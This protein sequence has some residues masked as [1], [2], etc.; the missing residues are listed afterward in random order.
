MERACSPRAPWWSGSAAWEKPGCVASQVTTAPC[1]FQYFLPVLGSLLV[2]DRVSQE[3]LATSIPSLLCPPHGHLPATAQVPPVSGAPCEWAGSAHSCARTPAVPA[4]G[5]SLPTPQHLFRC[6]CSS[7][8]LA[9]PVHS[10]SHAFWGSPGQ[11]GQG[12][13][14]SFTHGASVKAPLKKDVRGPSDGTQ[15]PGSP[16][17]PHPLQLGLW[18]PLGGSW[19]EFTASTSSGPCALCAS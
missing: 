3:T 8:I 11:R 13:T 10:W 18:E 16:W 17:V 12:C 6:R 9:S 2:L 7:L 1:R 19:E 15:S 5:S 4:Q 14:L